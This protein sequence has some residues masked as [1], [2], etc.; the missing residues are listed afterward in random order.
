MGGLAQVCSLTLTL[1]LTLILIQTLTLTVVLAVAVARKH[2]QTVG[3]LTAFAM[4]TPS[5]PGADSLVLWM[6]SGAMFSLTTFFF[7]H[8]ASFGGAICLAGT[9]EPSLGWMLIEKWFIQ[10][11]VRHLSF[12]FFFFSNA[13][14]LFQTLSK[15]LFKIAPNHLLPEIIRK[16]NQRWKSISTSPGTHLSLSGFSLQY[17]SQDVRGCFCRL[18]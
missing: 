12:L 15:E 9:V 6:K 1:A 2:L 7:S 17:V 5:R 16:H 8:L 4:E 14:T 10:S 3:A 13:S 11:P 18:I